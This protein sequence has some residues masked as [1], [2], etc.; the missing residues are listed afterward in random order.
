VSDKEKSFKMMTGGR[1][2]KHR[3]K[4]D[5][6]PRKLVSFN[7]SSS[8]LTVAQNKLERLSLK[9]FLKIVIADKT[10]I[11]S[12]GATTFNFKTFCI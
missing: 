11:G 12:T 9:S 1:D 6:R 8:S 3:T 7:L 10:K 2:E 5:L 4:A